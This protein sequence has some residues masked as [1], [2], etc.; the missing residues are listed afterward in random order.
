MVLRTYKYTHLL[1]GFTTSRKNISSQIQWTDALS[2]STSTYARVHT[3]ARSTQRIERS[4]KFK[5]AVKNVLLSVFDCWIHE[6]E[7]MAKQINIGRKEK[8]IRRVLGAICMVI[9]MPTE[10]KNE[11]RSLCLHHIRTISNVSYCIIIINGFASQFYLKYYSMTLFAS[12]WLFRSI[13]CLCDNA[14]R[15][16]DTHLFFR[17]VHRSASSSVCVY[18][19]NRK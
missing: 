12:L 8:H 4:H 15:Q 16:H 7:I 10:K 2:L 14:P 6:P 18:T 9:W 5:C 3:Y 13:T 1:K 17:F 19:H 11:K